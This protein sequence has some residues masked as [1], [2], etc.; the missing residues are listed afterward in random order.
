IDNNICNTEWCCSIDSVF[1][2]DTGG[3]CG[4]PPPVENGDIVE[5]PKATY[6]PSETVTYQCQNFYTMEG[7]PRVTC[8]NGHWSQPPTCRVACTVNDE[9]MREHNISLKWSYRN[10]IYVADG[11]T[12]EFV[13]LR[14]YKQHPN[15][16]SLRTNCADGKFDYPDCI[17][18]CIF[19]EN[20][21][22][23]QILTFL[24]FVYIYIPIHL[25]LCIKNHLKYLKD[26]GLAAKFVD[27]MDSK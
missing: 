24:F 1:V 20:Y 25:Y 12:V 23:S 21:F 13:C 10:K 11:N 18:V 26:L 27:V 3:K 16:R 4:H 17:P 7:S 6:F 14:G 15:T 8:Q 19:S 5:I 9:D 22:N 2:I